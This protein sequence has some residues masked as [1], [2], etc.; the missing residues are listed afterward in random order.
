MSATRSK[1]V[2]WHE[3]SVTRADRQHVLGQRGATLWFTGLSG[4]GKSTVAHAVEKAL[5]E[6]GAAAYV[7]DGDNVRHGLNGDLGFSPEDRKENV[8]RIGEVA[9]LFVDSGMLVLCAF[10]SPYRADRARI[11][12]AMEPDDFVEIYVQA[13]LET[14]RARDP[15]GLYEKADRGEIDDM[16]GVGAPYEAPDRPDLVLDTEAR[17]LGDN[18]SRVLAFL[19][20]GGYIRRSPELTG[21]E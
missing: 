8:R 16:T 5:L 10:I 17:D 1:N 21:N 2:R 19:E 6:R 15:K 7:L 18:V 9:G 4:S 12:E 3:G 20:S 11:R 14:C 13:S